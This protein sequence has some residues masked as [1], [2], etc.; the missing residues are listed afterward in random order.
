M[1]SLIFFRHV[2]KVHCVTSFFTL[3]PSF[4]CI[5]YRN[6]LLDICSGPGVMLYIILVMSY[7]NLAKGTLSSSKGKK[8]KKKKLQKQKTN[9]APEMLNNLP[10]VRQ[11]LT[12]LGFK[13]R[14]L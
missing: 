11:L 5:N 6:Y 4:A 3:L 12:Q 1:I 13:A 10:V 9:P 7:V 8:V 14:P 2:T